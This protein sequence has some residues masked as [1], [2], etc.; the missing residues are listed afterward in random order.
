MFLFFLMQISQNNWHETFWTTLLDIDL[1]LLLPFWID[2][3]AGCEK[4]LNFATKKINIWFFTYQTQSGLAI[5]KLLN[6]IKLLNAEQI[7]QVSFQTI[8][9]TSLFGYTKIIQGLVS[10]SKCFSSPS[11][12]F[13]K[14]SPNRVR[15][16]EYFSSLIPL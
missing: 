8:L 14:I 11:R 15:Q 3:P 4:Y 16:Y 10:Q 9:R 6:L 5:V 1:N 13:Y 2:T 12:I 7:T